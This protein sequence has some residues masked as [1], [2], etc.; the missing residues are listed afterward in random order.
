M[1]SDCMRKQRGNP[2]PEPMVGWRRHGEMKGF[3]KLGVRR[4]GATLARRRSAY[5]W[6]FPRLAA[7]GFQT[8]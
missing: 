1:L 7:V 3:L 6:F 5:G 4:V 2:F 8:G